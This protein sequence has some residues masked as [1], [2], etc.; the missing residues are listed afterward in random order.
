[1]LESLETE[2]I[3]LACVDVVDESGSTAKFDKKQGKKLEKLKNQLSKTACLK[4]VLSLAVGCRV[5][6]RHNIDVTVGL[7]NGSIGT[8]MGIHATHT[9]IIDLLTDV[10]GDSMAYVALSHVRTLMDN[11]YYHLII[12]LL[13]LVVP[14]LRKLTA[15]EVNFGMTNLYL[16]KVK[17]RRERFK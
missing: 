7:V 4:T 9:A 10:F 8:I 13:K 11:I 16:R 2:K 14:A 17:E 12:S 5:M 15:S 1:M 6:L 3:E